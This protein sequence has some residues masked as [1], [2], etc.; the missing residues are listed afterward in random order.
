MAFGIVA[1]LGASVGA[2]QAAKIDFKSV[3]RAWPLSVDV[4]KLEMVGPTTRRPFNPGQ[5]QAGDGQPPPEA[6]FIG[7]ARNGDHPPGIEPLP[8]DL[9]TSKDFYKDRAL[10]SDPRYFR[11]NSPAAIE[12][13]W[14]GNRRGTIG[15]HGPAS[16]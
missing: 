1:F 4:N 2:Q 10:W 11:C 5:G 12:D 14:G 9:Y 8:I 6:F 13:Q 3:G 15:D 7:S 16:G